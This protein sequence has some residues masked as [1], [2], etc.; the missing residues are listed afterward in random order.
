VLSGLRRIQT[1]LLEIAYLEE[2]SP[3]GD[4]VLL[5]HG[6]PDDILTWQHVT[7]RLAE[8]G[9]RTFCPYLR[10]Y[11]QTRFLQPST[12][13]SGQLSALGSDVIEFANTLGLK[14]FAIIGHDWGARAAY[15]AA[16]L[17][18]DRVSSCIAISVGW[19]TNDPAQELTLS[20]AR[21]YWY[22]WYLA[23]P[24]GDATLRDSRREFTRF[25]WSTWSPQW[26][27]TN[28]EFE[29]TAQSFDNPDWFDV[30]LNSYRNRWGWAAGDPRYAE[31]DRNLNPAPVI[32]APTLV[33]HGDG[34]ACN[35]PVT[36]EG[37][38]NKFSGPY[39]RKLVPGTGHF[40]QRE[41]SAF[42]ADEII[43]WLRAATVKER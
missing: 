6:W 7:R 15:I 29:A 10:G 38:E 23:T 32:A 24:R 28:A 26:K 9:Y 2:G 42:V 41:N 25:L 20:Q 43:E 8:A 5:L 21:N 4:P 19:G 18:P 33:L 30:T 27:F 14:R 12:F 31:M 1:S 39:S 3:A 17:Y 35:A 22:H 40:P 16:A 36:S 34:D 37:R 11:G 13:R